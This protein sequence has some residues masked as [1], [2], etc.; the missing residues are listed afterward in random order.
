MAHALGDFRDMPPVRSRIAWQ[1]QKSALARNAPLGV[2]DRAIFFAPCC[3]RQLDCGVNNGVRA[4]GNIGHN[5]K[6]ASF[7]RLAHGIGVRQEST[8]LVAMIHSALMRPSATA[9]N[10]STALR[11]GFVAIVGDIQKDCTMSLW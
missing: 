5:D 2:G 7:D 11:P 8:G 1:F 3:G 6:R 9:L 4:G 10:M